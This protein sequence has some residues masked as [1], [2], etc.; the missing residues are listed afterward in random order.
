MKSEVGDFPLINGQVPDHVV[1]LVSRSTARSRQNRLENANFKNTVAKCLM[2]LDLIDEVS[3]LLKALKFSGFL[4]LVFDLDKRLVGRC[5]D[6]AEGYFWAE[7]AELVV[8]AKNMDAEEEADRRAF[9]GTLAHELAHWTMT[10]VFKNEGLPYR[11]ESKEAECYRNILSKV[12]KETEKLHDR[13][14]AVFCMYDQCRWEVELIVVIPHLLAQFPFNSHWPTDGTKALFDFFRMSVLSEI[15]TFVSEALKHSQRETIAKLN[16]QFGF[17][18]F[19]SESVIKFETGYNDSPSV[20][21]IGC[22]HPIVALFKVL[23]N[24]SN[25]EKVICCDYSHDIIGPCDTKIVNCFRDLDECQALVIVCENDESEHYYNNMLLFFNIVVEKERNHISKKLII[26]VKSTLVDTLR[27]ILKSSSETFASLKMECIKEQLTFEMLTE[28]SKNLLLQNTV[29]FRGEGVILEDLIGVSERPLIDGM[30]IQRMLYDEEIVIGR[31]CSPERSYDQD[32]IICHKLVDKDNFMRLV[33][34]CGKRMGIAIFVETELVDWEKN[35]TIP[36]PQV[37]TSAEELEC[38]LQLVGGQHFTPF[39]VMKSNAHRTDQFS[40]S[41]SKCLRHHCKYSFAYWFQI[42]TDGR[43]ICTGAHCPGLSFNRKLLRYDEDTKG[44]DVQTFIDTEI[45]PRDNIIRAHVLNDKPGTG[46]SWFLNALYGKLCDTHWAIKIILK[47]AKESVDSL[48]SSNLTDEHVIKFIQHH[49]NIE[50]GFAESFLKYKIRNDSKYRL[51]LLFDGMEEIPWTETSSLQQNREKIAGLI[52]YLAEK[53][54]VQTITATRPGDQV[55]LTNFPC[56]VYKF[57]SIEDCHVYLKTK[58]EIQAELLGK[59]VDVQ[60]YIEMAGNLLDTPLHVNMLGEIIMGDLDNS[61]EHNKVNSVAT[62]YKAFTDIKY[63]NYIRERNIPPILQRQVKKDFQRLALFC[64]LGNKD[65]FKDYLAKSDLFEITNGKLKLNTELDSYYGMGL[66]N[67]HPSQGEVEFLHQTIPEYLISELILSWIENDTHEQLVAEGVLCNPVA[68]L[69]TFNDMLGHHTVTQDRISKYAAIIENGRILNFL[70]AIDRLAQLRF[71][72]LLEMCAKCIGESKEL[73]NLTTPEYYFTVVSDHS[74]YTN[75]YPLFPISEHCGDDVIKRY[76]ELGF[77]PNY[78]GPNGRSIMHNLVKRGSLKIIEEVERLCEISLDVEDDDG[79]S[80]VH[81]AAI[82]GKLEILK[83]LQGKNIN[84]LIACKR[85]KS[86][87]YYAIEYEN[88]DVVMWILNG[89]HD[90]TFQS[91]ENLLQHVCYK[92]RE[93]IVAQLLNNR[94][95]E[96]V[97][98]KDSNGMTPILLAAERGH[99]KVAKLLVEAGADMTISSNDKFSILHLSSRYGNQSMIEWILE[100]EERKQIFLSSVDRTQRTPL[101]IAAEGGHLEAVKFLVKAGANM[102][103]RSEGGQTLLHHAVMGGNSTLVGWIIRQQQN[104]ESFDVNATMSNDK[105][106]ILLAAELGQLDIIKILINARADVLRR[107]KNNYSIIHC[108][109]FSESLEVVEWC[110][111]NMPRELIESRDFEGKTPIHL[112]G[113]LGLQSIV[114]ELKDAGGELKSLSYEGASVLHYVAASG[115]PSLMQWCL[116]ELREQNFNVNHRDKYGR[117]PLDIAAAQNDVRIMKFLQDYGGQRTYAHGHIDLSHRTLNRG[118]I[119][120]CYDLTNTETAQPSDKITEDS[121]KMEN[122]PVSILNQHDADT[123]AS[124]EVQNMSNEAQEMQDTSV[125][126]QATACNPDP[127][128]A[129]AN[130]PHEGET[131]PE[132]LL[133][134]FGKSLIKLGEKRLKKIKIK[135]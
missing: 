64:L 107:S 82:C 56:R 134:D 87:M 45:L 84:L 50:H 67:K 44:I 108:A 37:F 113:K 38:T 2:A 40:T 62:L 54:W 31:N 4:H 25:N 98:K 120:G 127:P 16:K 23:K 89:M 93:D 92:G 129:A 47:F 123:A 8:A 111:K 115:K 18:G 100:S 20:L 66:I 73:L 71:E 117:T 33:S 34:N 15:Q 5:K 41:F 90:T 124:E 53:T 42:K 19:Y 81:E 29:T 32:F 80:L 74:I 121:S 88:W 103:T 72:N 6:E 119:P 110:L 83:W 7:N 77:T 3:W 94:W 57:Q 59:R 10:I 105:T 11:N 26:I 36:L 55:W 131:R 96:D 1:Y 27:N 133:K 106:P 21:L 9:L 52:K 102:S 30:L 75:P 116:S 104:E 14:K 63:L 69:G 49:D 76:L 35:L 101:H 135:F 61:R 114:R 118:P 132:V 125:E 130:P 39:V 112:A 78:K 68:S 46:K 70:Q 95:K 99:L 24:F 65:V 60:N 109:V 91:D 86:A 58:S 97:N 85:N 126:N 48:P 28:G 79:I 22:D 51:L 43:I 13:F 122:T 128:P 17:Q 12:G